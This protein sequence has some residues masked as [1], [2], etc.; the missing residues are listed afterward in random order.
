MTTTAQHLRNTVDNS[1]DWRDILQA[2]ADLGG[3]KHDRRGDDRWRFP[4]GSVA[5][6]RG[7]VSSKPTVDIESPEVPLFVGNVL[8]VIGR[9][10][11]VYA[12]TMPDVPH[13][14]TVRLRAAADADYFALYDCIMRDGV[15][16]FWRGREGKIKYPRPARYL[17]PGDGWRYWSMSPKRSIKPYEEGRHSLSISRHINRC[18]L[19]EW[20]KLRARG[21]IFT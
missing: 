20:E 18:T 16:E 13:E 12:Q 9:L 15:I 14:Y 11:F 10:N 1:L 19:A 6:I 4:D 17:Y 5:L 2:I 3:E 21:W 7:L 8:G